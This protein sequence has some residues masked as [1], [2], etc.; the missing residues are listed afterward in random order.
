MQATVDD[1][2]TAFA[3][4]KP[5]YY[6]SRQRFTTPP[7]DEAPR[8]T[9]LAAGKPLLQFGISDGSTVYFKD[10]G[11]QVLPCSICASL[12]SESERC[13]LR[14]P[15]PS[16]ARQPLPSCITAASSEQSV[17]EALLKVVCRLLNGILK[18]ALVQISPSHSQG[19]SDSI[20]THESG[21]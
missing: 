5:K 13:H 12:I 17:V 7:T 4:A 15:F 10:L 21:S 19:V 6:Q 9:A 2:K 16:T 1:L 11:P 8:G 18:R 14:Q 3:E 20:Q